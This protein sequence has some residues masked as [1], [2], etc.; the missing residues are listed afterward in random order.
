MHVIFGFDQLH[1]HQSYNKEKLNLQAC[2]GVMMKIERI[3]FHRLEQKLRD[4]LSWSGGRDQERLYTTVVEIHSDTGHV[5]WADGWCPIELIQ[6]RPELLL[7]RS[8]FE[9]MAVFDELGGLGRDA[10][11]MGTLDVAL[12]DLAGR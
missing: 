10:G 8:P 12:W 9:V 2:Q 1:V 11:C 4:P 6:Q 7:G 3:C 5:G